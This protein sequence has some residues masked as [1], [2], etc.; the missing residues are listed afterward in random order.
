M[1][2]ELLHEER[3][4]FITIACAVELRGNYV[5]LYLLL[6]KSPCFTIYKY[7]PI[8]H[9]RCFILMKDGKKNYGIKQWV[10]KDFYYGDL[11]STWARFHT[12]S[13][14]KITDVN[15]E[16]NQAQHTTF[17]RLSE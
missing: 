7:R 16:T 15:R 6:F 13:T 11:T 8:F 2:F 5:E 10:F 3:R 12:E 4:S 9:W 1:T 14:R 17:I